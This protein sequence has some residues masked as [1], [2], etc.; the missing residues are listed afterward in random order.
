[1]IYLPFNYYNL[2]TIFGHMNIESY[3]TNKYKEIY[4]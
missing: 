4:E 1:M 3:V 2:L